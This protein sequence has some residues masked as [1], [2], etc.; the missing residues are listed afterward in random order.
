MTRPAVARDT[1][2]SDSGD[3]VFP[4]LP[5]GTYT[6]TFE[7]TGSKKD[8]RH[9]ISLD[10]NQVITLNM[11]MQLGAAQEV[12]DVTS[13][14]PLVDTSSTQLG[15]VVNN[16]SVNELPPTRATPHQFLQLQ[17]GVQSQLGSSGGISS[18]AVTRARFR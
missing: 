15:A 7:L 18:T 16:R 3:Y 1:Q 5:V 11:I 12:V 10:V 2:S 17:P 13:E 9:A 6:L 4:D 14:A 8:V